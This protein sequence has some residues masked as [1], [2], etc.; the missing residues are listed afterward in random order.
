MEDNWKVVFTCS[1]L[2]DAN[3][4]KAVLTDNEIDSVIINQ[5][6]SNLLF[7]SIRVYVSEEDYEKAKSIIE[8]LEE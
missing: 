4:T 7:G 2:Y 5:K 1:S 3:L 6:D 8:S